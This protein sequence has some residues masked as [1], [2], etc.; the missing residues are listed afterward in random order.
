M[1]GTAYEDTSVRTVLGYM[2][3]LHV[4][5]SSDV[6]LTKSKL[7]PFEGGGNPERVAL[8]GGWVRSILAGLTS[9]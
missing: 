2:Y 6:R 8:Y 5:C 3:M 4:Q 7:L 9:K 1:K